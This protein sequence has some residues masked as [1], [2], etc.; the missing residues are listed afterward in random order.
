MAAP[1]QCAFLF[2]LPRSLPKS[3]S[4]SRVSA[5][6]YFIHSFHL[7]RNVWI[8]AVAV[9]W[10]W[11]VKPNWFLKQKWANDES[12]SN[13]SETCR[14]FLPSRVISFG[15]FFCTFKG[16]NAGFDVC[17]HTDVTLHTTASRDKNARVSICLFFLRFQR[18]CVW[19]VQGVIRFHQKASH[20]HLWS[21]KTIHIRTVFS[22]YY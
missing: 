8:A 17:W 13:F 20:Q 12:A 5:C 10:L 21:Q 11:P 15:P 7:L 2:H 4:G 14:A 22:L 16:I 19:L 6:H 3:M 9:P 18:A 1:R